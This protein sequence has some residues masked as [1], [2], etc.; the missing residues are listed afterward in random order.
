MA[1]GASTPM[2]L[3]G[4]IG[5]TNARFALAEPTSGRPRLSGFKNLRCEDY[6][7]LEAAI[8]AYFAGQ[9]NEPRP[10]SA[11]IAV[12]GPV[13]DG[14]ITFTNLG[15]K[16]SET[17][18]RKSL[19]FTSATLIND[20]AGLA[21]AAPVL[22]PEDVRHIGPVI[23]G[24]PNANVAMIGAGTGFGASALAR[25]GFNDAVLTTEGGHAGFAPTDALEAEVWRILSLKFGRVSI[26]RILSGPGLLNLYGALVELEGVQPKCSS[27]DGVSRCADEGDPLALRT[28]QLFCDVLG[29]VAG[30]FDLTY[31]AQGGV[32]IAGGVAP[33]LFAHLEKSDF[34]RRF[35][36]K[37]RFESYLRAIPSAVV[38]QPHA[39]LL[40]AARASVKAGHGAR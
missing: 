20:Y 23:Q 32:F 24:H 28:V 3:V 27:P 6:P 25:D 14:A 5:G 22:G 16:V 40:G 34:R 15:W 17:E 12:A 21:L 13:V 10:S 8:A 26:E 31:G 4:D 2:R 18:L 30:D 36:A 33:S 7:S 38:T 1:D 29:S 35:E 19:G 9:P 11:V 37:G 39:A